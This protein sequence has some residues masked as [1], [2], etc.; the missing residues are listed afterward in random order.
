L[1]PVGSTPIDCTAV[2]SNGN[3]GTASFNVVVNDT[4]A[5][6]LT[7]PAAASAEAASPAG[8]S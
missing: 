7:A 4:T 3:V 6:E 8:R 1:F 5:P 2:D